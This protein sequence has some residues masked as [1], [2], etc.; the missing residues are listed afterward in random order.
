MYGY[1][2]Y[3]H[4]SGTSMVLTRYLCHLITESIVYQTQFI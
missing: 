4:I 1:Y 3:F 2:Q